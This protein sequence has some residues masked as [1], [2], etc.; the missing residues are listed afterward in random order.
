MASAPT[1]NN[2]S[3]T[4]TL[5]MPDKTGIRA[6]KVSQSA[7][8]RAQSGKLGV[9]IRPAYWHI[10]IPWPMLTATERTA[11][12]TAYDACA[13]VS[14]VLTLPDGRY[15]TVL[16]AHYDF[17]EENIYDVKDTPYYTVELEFDEVL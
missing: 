8:R 14:S 13:G 12:Q 11:L 7:S 16:A 4:Y 10:V 5:P 6:R 15:W 17:P 3:T 1:W 9:D 2:G